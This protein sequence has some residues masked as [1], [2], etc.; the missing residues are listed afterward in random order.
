MRVK[1]KDTMKRQEKDEKFQWILFSDLLLAKLKPLLISRNQAKT[2][3][4][5]GAAKYAKN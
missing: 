5:A 4:N 3:K 1:E 2:K